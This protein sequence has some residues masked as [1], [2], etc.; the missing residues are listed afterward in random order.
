MNKIIL[1][2]RLTT[3]PELKTT[4]SNLSVTSFS[5]AV[6]RPYSK[7]GEQ[8]QADFIN[9][10]CWRQRAEFICKYF[11]KGQLIALDGSLQTRQY[12]DNNGNNRYIT[13]VLADNVYFTGDRKNTEQQNVTTSSSSVNSTNAVKQSTVQTQQQQNEVYNQLDLNFINVNPYDD[14]LPF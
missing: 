3:T 9:I 10:V 7:Q 6:D 5:I 11:T 12:Q 2:G 13:E 1:M 8:R 14:D 4:Q